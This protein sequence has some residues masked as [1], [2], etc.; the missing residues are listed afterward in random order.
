MACSHAQRQCGT[1]GVVWWCQGHGCTNQHAKGSQ[2][3]WQ[4]QLIGL[5][6]NPA[7]FLRQRQWRIKSNAHAPAHEHQGISTP[8]H[9][10]ISTPG[11]CCTLWEP[12]HRTHVHAVCARSD[13]GPTRPEQAS[14]CGRSGAGGCTCTPPIGVGGTEQELT[15]SEHMAGLLCLFD[16][17]PLLITTTTD[18]SVAGCLLYMLHAYCLPT[19]PH[20][21]SVLC[22]SAAHVHSPWCPPLAARHH[23]LC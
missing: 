11:P 5:H 17:C 14:R 10:G 9:Q 18:R 13:E 8:L 23:L 6:N 4:H 15:S 22:C 3:K 2:L 7:L 16:T 19:P 20:F 1:P 21:A 12:S